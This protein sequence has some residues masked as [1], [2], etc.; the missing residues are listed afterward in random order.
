MGLFSK[1]F[2]PSFEQRCDKLP[3]SVDFIFS[4]S[5]RV[6]EGLVAV[7]N[8]D[9]LLGLRGAERQSVE[10]TQDTL[11]SWKCTGLV[12]LFV[13]LIQLH[14]SEKERVWKIVEVF[15]AGLNNM[16]P[17]AAKENIKDNDDF[18]PHKLLATQFLFSNGNIL[19]PLNHDHIVS[20]Y[21]KALSKLK[22][23]AEDV[24]DLI[25]R[26]EQSNTLLSNAVTALALP[27]K[28]F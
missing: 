6:C 13:E 14:P 23:R 10:L 3:L 21:K 24:S 1:F 28:I 12:P 4:E 22:G 20:Q 15:I 8:E 11:L 25:S 16:H 5:D 18:G 27:S 2:G 7:Y 9:V 17:A 26:Y 19:V